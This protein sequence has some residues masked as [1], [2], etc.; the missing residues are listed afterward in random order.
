[1]PNKQVDKKRLFWNIAL[2]PGIL[3]AK[4]TD[5]MIP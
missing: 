2:K 1:M 4:P 5:Q 3:C